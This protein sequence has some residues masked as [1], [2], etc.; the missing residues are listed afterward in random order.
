[1]CAEFG[2][3]IEGPSFVADAGPAL[4]FSVSAAF[5]EEACLWVVAVFAGAGCDAWCGEVCGHGG[6]VWCVGGFEGGEYEVAFVSVVDGHPFAASCFAG[7]FGGVGCGVAH[8]VECDVFVG[9]VV[10]F[11]SVVVGALCAGGDE[12]SV[13]GGDFVSVF[14]EEG[15]GFPVSVFRVVEAGAVGG[16]VEIS[17]DDVVVDVWFVGAGAEE[18]SS[19]VF[20]LGAAVGEVCGVGVDGAACP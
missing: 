14:V 3:D 18:L 15:G 19:V 7:L 4:V 8:F 12:V 5:G 9:G 6:R 2:V 10:G 13:F 20:H 17:E 16:V 1:M 11:G